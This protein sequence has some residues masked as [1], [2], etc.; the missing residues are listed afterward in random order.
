MYVFTVSIVRE[1]LSEYPQWYMW[2]QS[3][4]TSSFSHVA[5]R[6]RQRCLERDSARISNH[7][8]CLHH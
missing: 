4:H 3:A 1:L 5:S 2:H 8:R 7:W 6:N